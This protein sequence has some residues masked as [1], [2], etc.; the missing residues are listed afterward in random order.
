[1]G[2]GIWIIYN[3]YYIILLRARNHKILLGHSFAITY[4]NKVLKISGADI[5]LIKFTEVII[6]LS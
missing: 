2:T 4:Y 1:M 3:M 6:M 5:R